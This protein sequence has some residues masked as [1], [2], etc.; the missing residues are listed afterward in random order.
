MNESTAQLAEACRRV[1]ERLAEAM[2][3]AIKAMAELGRK[4][5]A[6]I[7]KDY[8][9]AGMPYGDSDDGMMRWFEER[10]AR[11]RQQYDAERAAERQAIL[12]DPLG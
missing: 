6:A 3:P 9:R 2:R 1:N 5:H 10:S 11:A 12:R 8:E 4:M 7:R